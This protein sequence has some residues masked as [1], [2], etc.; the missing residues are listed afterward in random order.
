MRFL[1]TS[2]G[3]S[4]P[5]DDVREITNF[6]SGRFG[7]QIGRQA[8][9]RGHTLDY[10]GAEKSDTPFTFH[11]EQPSLED[12][13]KLAELAKQYNQYL[14]HY[15]RHKFRTFHDYQTGLERLVRKLEPDV[16]IL[17]AAVSDYLTKRAPGKI[18]SSDDLKIELEHAPKVI[19]SVRG[20]MKPGAVLIGFKLLVDVNDEQLVDAARRSISLNGCDAV[21]ANDLNSLK[22]GDHRILFVTKS[23]TSDYV[24]SRYPDDPNRLAQ[25]VIEESL[26]L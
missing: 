19:S 4:V 22:R 8:L 12:V 5:L 14:A 10:F 6:S 17:V 26:G 2:G 21:V 9:F 3:T 20:W 25:I 1:I 15:T 18:R 13:A 23:A 24:A 7:A 16:V 11:T